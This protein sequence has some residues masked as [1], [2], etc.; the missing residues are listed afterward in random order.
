MFPSAALMPPC[1]ATVCERVGNSF[2]MHAVLNPSS[3]S[4]NAARSPAPPAPTTTASYVWSIIVYFEVR[5]PCEAP[6][7]GCSFDSTAKFR[8]TADS[9]VRGAI[10]NSLLSMAIL[11][12][13][14]FFNLYSL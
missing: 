12:S 5:C 1:A 13:L 2:E 8:L 3:T 10:L 7:S 9:G 14:S 11:G 4:P 6:F